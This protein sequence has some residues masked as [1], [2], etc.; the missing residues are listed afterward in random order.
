VAPDTRSA[1]SWT[2]L[3][4]VTIA[5]VLA[6]LAWKVS[7]PNNQHRD[8]DTFGL[9]PP[10]ERLSQITAGYDD[11]VT[12]VTAHNFAR[13]GFLRTH[14]LPNRK[15]APLVSYFDHDRTQC[16]AIEPPANPLRYPNFW[17]VPVDQ[18]SLD[19]DCIYTHYPPLADWAYG[20]MASLGLD[21]VLHY[22]LAAVLLNC[23]LLFL[24]YRWLRTR[25]AP[26]AAYGA[27]L[28]LALSPA[29]FE[30]A[31][32]LFYQ[33]FQYLLLFGGLLSLHAWTERGSR[34]A[35]LLTWALF[36][37]EALVSPELIVFFGLAACSAALGASRG[38]WRRIGALAFLASAPIAAMLLHVGLQVSLFGPAAL[39]ELLGTLSSRAV[40][41]TGGWGWRT[42]LD[43]IHE[44]LLP[45]A[46]MGAGLLA[47]L[48]SARHGGP[49][50]RPRLALLG[51]FLA[52]GLSFTAVF[53]GTAMVHS[54]MMY[55]HVMPFVTLLVAFVLD[56]A[57][58]AA[59]VVPRWEALPLRAR[60]ATV[61]CLALAGVVLGWSAVRSARA[62]RAEVKWTLEV[63][64]HHEPGNQG[65]EFLDVVTWSERGP[66]P[67]DLLLLHAF[68][69]RRTEDPAEAGSF[70]HL[71]DSHL[72]VWW[73]EPRTFGETA[74]ATDR[75]AA[76][77]LAAACRVEVYD[78]GAFVP[79][80]CS[81]AP[82]L[83]A[84]P[85]AADVSWVRF[86]CAG[87]GRAVQLTCGAL[88]EPIPLHEIE[89]Y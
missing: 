4:L 85:R 87:R 51:V 12:I 80:R 89:V 76:E 88:A 81:A 72:D 84:D 83:S 29:F 66:L 86:P 67:Y 33:P 5:A 39:E 62:I 31:G 8:L 69:G 54:W 13:D 6:P 32:A 20:A 11:V 56:G 34:R 28:F 53:P 18:V 44:K 37:C 23:A 25:V 38:T 82:L 75:R 78:G 52:G 30:W 50:L 15:F 79:M 77:R 59:R 24:V 46:L 26:G 71:P 70:G 43:R 42:G 61:L 73:L 36:F 45:P 21:R 68:D 57:I 74:I 35:L 22:K 64:A 65:I 16:R 48:L 60:G 58:H 19:S 2:A 63:A 7:L 9:P 40:R 47:V 55:R 41:Q 49:R 3:A 10:G 27:M 1:R 14:L 17:G